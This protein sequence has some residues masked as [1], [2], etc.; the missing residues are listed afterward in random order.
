MSTIITS[1]EIDGRMYYSATK[2][3]V[4][5]IAMKCGDGWFVASHRKALGPRHIGGGKHYKDLKEVSQGC[6]ALQG[7]DL[8]VTEIKTVN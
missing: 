4:E 6:K 7:I 2:R 1:S 8:L 5:Y 3:G